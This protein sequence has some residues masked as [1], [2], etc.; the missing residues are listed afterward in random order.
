MK[1]K[2]IFFRND[3]VRH[4]IENE[5]REFVA[6]FT[7]EEVPVTL[8]VEPANVTPEVVGWLNHLQTK[9]PNLI[10]LIQHGYDHNKN[11]KYA[12]ASEF[13]RDR[14]YEDQLVDLKKGKDL[15]DGYFKNWFPAMAFPYG[16]YNTHSLKGLDVLKFKVFCSWVDFSLKHKVK[17]SLGRML[18]KDIIF[19]KKVNHHYRIRKNYQF[20]ELSVSVNVIKKYIN[21]NE[22]THFSLDELVEQVETNFKDTNV[23]GILF[24]H[25]YH[26][27]QFEMI[28]QLVKKL[29]QKGYEFSTMENLYMNYN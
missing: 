3:D 19:K 14:G 26:T 18:S 15:M 5:L 29:K 4:T 24:H 7:S 8:A 9:H 11:G 16:S 6:I 2:T 27:G 23:V 22:A 28:R 10:E 20:L 13:G 12:K 21:L 17:N 1:K 25:R